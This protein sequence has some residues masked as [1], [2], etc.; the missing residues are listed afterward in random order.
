MS[1]HDDHLEKQ[2]L[3]FLFLTSDTRDGIML[4]MKSIFESVFY[5]LMYKHLMALDPISLVRNYRTLV[6]VI[7]F[8]YVLGIVT[9]SHIINHIC[10]PSHQNGN[11]GGMTPN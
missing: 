10:D 9:Y 7:L 8:F 1:I 5:P 11:V 2:R 4:L 6:M 3:Q